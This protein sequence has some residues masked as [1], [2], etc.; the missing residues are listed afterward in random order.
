M[1]TTTSFR[2]GIKTAVW[3]VLAASLTAHLFAQDKKLK[4]VAVAV[5]DLGNPFFV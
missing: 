3:L 4:S 1:N 2:I 5:N